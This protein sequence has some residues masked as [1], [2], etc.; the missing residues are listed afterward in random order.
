MHLHGFLARGHRDA[1]SSVH[2]GGRLLLRPLLTSSTNK[3]ITLLDAIEEDDAV[4]AA[5][6]HGAA[7]S[8]PQTGTMTGGVTATKFGAGG[9]SARARRR[10]AVVAGGATLLGVLAIANGIRKC[11]SPSG[12]LASNP[13]RATASTSALSERP[14]PSVA[15]RGDQ[16]ETQVIPVDRLPVIPLNSAAI[17]AVEPRRKGIESSRPRQTGPVASTADAARA[18]PVPPKPGAVVGDPWAARH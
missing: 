12:P 14:A 5:R 13:D 8:M 9:S 6:V 3:P 11:S 4:A 10:V 1:R 7:F 17:P 18:P 16:G 2:L 15:P